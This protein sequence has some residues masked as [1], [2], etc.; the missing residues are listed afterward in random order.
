LN[1]NVTP[2]VYNGLVNLGKILSSVNATEDLKLLKAEKERLL[3]TSA[4]KGEI[5]TRGV[6]RSKIYW[7]QYFI[8]VAG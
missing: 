8:I 6:V 4:F 2:D 3:I 1:I 7:E 5:L